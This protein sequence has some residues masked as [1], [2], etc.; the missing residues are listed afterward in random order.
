MMTAYRHTLRAKGLDDCEVLAKLFGFTES[1]ARIVINQ[2]MQMRLD[3]LMVVA[4]AVRMRPQTLIDRVLTDRAPLSVYRMSNAAEAERIRVKS[5]LEAV[6]AQL[7]AKINET[8][9]KLSARAVRRMV[10]AWKSE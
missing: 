8:P 6:T 7:K 5:E 2:P 10:K 9:K 3:E 1:R 4:A